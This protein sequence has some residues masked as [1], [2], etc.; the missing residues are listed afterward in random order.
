MHR[1]RWWTS[2]NGGYFTP[3][4][5]K[6]GRKR[7]PGNR[8]SSYTQLFMAGLKASIPWGE[9]LLMQLPR[10]VMMLDAAYPAAPDRDGTNVR[11]ATQADIDK[12]LG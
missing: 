10:L 2:C 11:E 8:K 12:L 5:P 6:T 9:L 4:I 1:R 7:K 3:E